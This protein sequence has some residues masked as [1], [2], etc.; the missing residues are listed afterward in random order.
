[1]KIIT[2]SRQDVLT[3][4]TARE[5]LQHNLKVEEVCSR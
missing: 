4:Q 5:I 1:V 2:V 3:D